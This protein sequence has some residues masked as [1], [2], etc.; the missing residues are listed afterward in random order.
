MKKVE[1][2]IQSVYSKVTQDII[3]STICTLKRLISLR[4]FLKVAKEARSVMF[5]FK[6]EYTTSSKRE[7]VYPQIINGLCDN[8]PTNQHNLTKGQQCQEKKTRHTVS[9]AIKSVGSSTL[10]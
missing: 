10:S 9:A 4:S 7:S 3:W 5:N 2:K 1:D 8:Q 6:L